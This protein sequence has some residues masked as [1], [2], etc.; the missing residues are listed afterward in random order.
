MMRLTSLCLC[1]VLGFS[2]VAGCSVEQGPVASADAAAAPPPPPPDVGDIGR[3]LACKAEPRREL[4]ARERCQVEALAAR[5]TPADD[6]LV[7]CIASPDGHRVGGGCSH[8]CSFGPHRGE[9]RPPGWAGCDAIA[10]P[11]R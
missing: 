10:G 7:S 6:C 2:V 3:F 8:V 9:P 5:C 4:S 11:T 1:V